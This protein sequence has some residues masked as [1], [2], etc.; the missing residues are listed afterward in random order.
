MEYTKKCN[1]RRLQKNISINNERMLHIWKIKHFCWLF[2]C[3]EK[4]ENAFIIH[5]SLALNDPA[6]NAGKTLGG[7]KKLLICSLFL[8]R[9]SHL[10]SQG[11]LFFASFPFDVEKRAKKGKK[12]A[13]FEGGKWK[14]DSDFKD[15]RLFVLVWNSR[16]LLVASTNGNA[17]VK[18]CTISFVCADF[19][20]TNCT[21]SSELMWA[22]K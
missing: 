7:K 20:C 4:R 9:S 14:K 12:I 2:F 1:V 16:P 13:V 19:S 11:D 5:T 8:R 3:L 21:P 15:I 10:T 17:K 18:V 6:K 22:L